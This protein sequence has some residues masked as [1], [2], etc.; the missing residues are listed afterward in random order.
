MGLLKILKMPDDFQK[1]FISFIEVLLRYAYIKQLL[2]RFKT[3]G[4]IQNFLSKL[5]ETFCNPQ[6]W[7]IY[8]KSGEYMSSIVED[9][10]GDMDITHIPIFVYN[11]EE[12]GISGRLNR[13]IM[14]SVRTALTTA[15]TYWEYCTW[16]PAD[17]MDE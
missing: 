13:T 17:A 6:K 2:H 5:R 8:H 15:G 9:T 10:F 1:D 7:C 11:S 12:N 16:A 4:T 14:N 3:F